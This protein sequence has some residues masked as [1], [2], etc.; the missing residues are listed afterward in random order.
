MKNRTEKIRQ[1]NSP[2]KSA[3][4]RGIEYI[5]LLVLLAVL[6][7]RATYTESPHIATM[8]PEQALTNQAFSLIIS[9]VL[10][11]CVV[12]WVIVALYTG[13]VA[14]R[15][16]WIEVGIA[17]FIAA[18]AVGIAVASDKRSA[19]TDFVTFL[20]PMLTAV[21]LV[22]I[23]DCTGKVRLVLLLLVA[24]AILNL[25]QCI[26]QATTSNAMMIEQYEQDPQLQLGPLGIKEGS[27]KQWLYEHRLYS[28][29]IR[30]FFKTSNSAGSFAILALSALVAAVFR[31]GRDAA[32]PETVFR[33]NF[34]WLV[35][36]LAVAAL[37]ITLSKGAI[38]AATVA[39]AM[40]AVYLCF[41]GILR[42]HRKAIFVV[43]ILL[44]LLAGAAIV[45]YG[46]AHGTLPGGNS[47]LVRWQY[48][49]AS[50]QMFCEHPFGVGPGNF[51]SYYL[52]YK[53]AAAIE[54]VK[55]PHNFL[56]SILT[57]YGPLGLAGF[58]MAFAVPMLMV[59][60]RPGPSAPRPRHGD[61]LAGRRNIRW[62][63]AALFVGAAILVFR[64]ILAPLAAT[65]DPVAVAFAI[66]YLYLVPLMVFVIAVWLLWR[67][68][69]ATNDRPVRS[70]TSVSPVASPTS[71]VSPAS[72]ASAVIFCGL[73][74]VL[75]ANLI[76]FALF[77]PGVLTAFWMMV[78]CMVALDR[79]GT[80]RAVILFRPSGAMRVAIAAG[81]AAIFIGC[82][83]YAVIPVV[84]AG[85]CQQRAMRDI[86]LRHQLLDRASRA[87]ALSPEHDNL[88]GRAY[89]QQYRDTAQSDTKL[90]TNAAECFM[91]AVGKDAANFKNYEKLA[92]VYLLLADRAGA[93]QAETYL[94]MAFDNLLLAIERYPEM[95]RLHL[96][97]A[98]TA[99]RLG[100]DDMAVAH[101]QKTVDIEDAFRGQFRIMYPGDELVSRLGKEAYDMARQKA[102]QPGQ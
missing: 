88:H 17:M 1:D 89:L 40:F 2:G 18:G 80:N 28:K 35:A 99:E 73:A 32:C 30:G 50:W 33:R 85:S 6:A 91:S 10:L 97:L 8:D 37:L 69:T 58:V 21:L 93:G 43:C 54:T 23:L 68:D 36:L 57:Q 45:R 77:E 65:D 16:G 7:I 70:I 46:N 94:S 61:A 26:E 60:F 76:D 14:C 66:F 3:L 67:M 22:Q 83:Y 96:K 49:V 98:Q 41:G 31:P 12:I 53:V 11:L 62:L 4:L 72:V 38:A 5:L 100:R 71:A 20:A 19:V 55:D 52:H 9:S 13:T 102:E 101:Y 27:F 24:M 95:D 75:T 39:G 48:W 34:V 25:Y 86:G 29:D 82:L 63:P 56:L 74:G 79:M 84:R 64:P 51:A 87:D 78:A 92:D 44:M 59:V 15:F 81:V 42:R 90:P 47:M